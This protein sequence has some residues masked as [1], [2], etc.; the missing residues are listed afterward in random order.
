MKEKINGVLVINKK[1]GMTSRDVVNEICKIFNTKKIGHTGTLDPL[2]EGVLVVTIGNATKISELLTAEY[3]E[4]IAGAI[5]GIKTDTYDIE[6]KVID[7]KPVKDNLKLDKIISSYKKT[8]MQEV[9]I[10]S[11]VK[12]NGKKLYEYARNNEEVELPKKKVTI[13]EIELLSTDR[14][15]FMFKALVSKGCYIR[16]LINDIG[17]SLN[18][19]ATMTK[20]IRTKLGKFNIENS[21]T[22][23]DIR[24]NNYKLYSIDEALDYPVI[25]IEDN[26]Y[27]KISNGVKINNKYKIKDKVIFKYK[28]KLLGIYERDKDMLKTWKNF[29]TK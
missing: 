7:N 8:Y 18:T 20:L 25:E 21:Y 11:A 10:Y 13:K 4:Y 27:K 16:S 2:A 19:Y 12:V 26:L 6:G 29:N 23:D 9:P 15:E 14:N 1:K 17:E 24:N 3:K 5:L 22:L 28:D